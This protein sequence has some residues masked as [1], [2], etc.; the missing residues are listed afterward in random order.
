MHKQTLKSESQTVYYRELTGLE[1]LIMIAK[2]RI[3]KGSSFLGEASLK[4]GRKEWSGTS[5]LD[6]AI[7][8]LEFGWPEGRD[9]L[10]SSIGSMAIDDLVGFQLAIEPYFTNAGDEADI[11]RYLQG[12]PEN[13]VAYRQRVD[14]LGKRATLLVNSGAHH[15]VPAESILNRGA[16]LLAVHDV[17]QKSGYTLGITM[18][19]T[20]TSSMHRNDTYATEY[21]IPI[22]KPGEYLDE[23]TIAFCIA[24][25]AFLRRLM[26]ALN[27]TEDTDIRNYM[28]YFYDGGYGVPT[29]VAGDVETATF[30][31]DKGEGM[32]L[33]DS[34]DIMDYT[35]Q[36]V[37]RI[38]SEMVDD[39]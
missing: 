34:K 16:A 18:V 2:E 26:F 7:Q 30:V 17:L 36:I 19:E 15:G 14:K 3:S 13:M 6:E 22:M 33:R 12:E 20:C 10:R 23:D 39:Y 8:L 27:E 28:G 11:D 5:T 21:R 29:N 1:E 37:D 32:D 24:H 9:M 35:Q 25:P 4:A 31:I 38:K